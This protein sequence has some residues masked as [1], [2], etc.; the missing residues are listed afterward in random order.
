MANW[1]I[2]DI[3]YLYY[4]RSQ[5]VAGKASYKL[6]NNLTILPSFL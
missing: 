3:A 4:P 5:D 1:I 6:S 2:V